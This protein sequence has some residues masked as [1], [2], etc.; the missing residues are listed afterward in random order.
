MAESRR[1]AAYGLAL[2]GDEPLLSELVAAG[3]VPGRTA[4]L[5]TATAN[6]LHAAWPAE[7]SRRLSTETPEPG[8][9]PRT[10]DEHPRAGWLL[11]APGWGCARVTP[12]GALVEC[13]RDDAEDWRWQRFLVGRALP[14]AAVAAGLEVLHAA[15]VV[16]DGRALAVTGSSG[17]GKSSVAAALTLRGA[18]LLTDDVLAFERDGERLV[19]HPGP[20]VLA[21]RVAEVTTLGDDRLERVGTVAG[22]GGGKSYMTV[23]AAQ[24]PVDLARL[25]VLRRGADPG[26]V[27][28]EPLGRPPARVLLSALFLPELATPARLRGQLEV[29]EALGGAVEVVEVRSG[30]DASAADVAEAL[31]T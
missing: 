7:G 9:P 15:A 22:E 8:A 3:P 25:A 1:A 23:T 31:A 28:V 11:D 26:G 10:I 19:A 21:L 30:S 12:D 18:A 5:R 16:L 20:P 2:S 4:V 24:T 13:A 14:F 27:V 17:A 29:L 6:D